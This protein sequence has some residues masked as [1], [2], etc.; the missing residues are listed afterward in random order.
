MES[1]LDGLI[2][3]AFDLAQKRF[4]QPVNSEKV[5]GMDDLGIMRTFHLC[6]RVF[7]FLVQTHIFK[8]CLCGVLYPTQTP[9]TLSEWGTCTPRSMRFLAV[10]CL[11]KVKGMND[12]GITRTFHNLLGFA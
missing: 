8:K 3:H 6:A 5:K 11:G 10:Y 9:G 12:R 2:I 1:S 4:F 7:E